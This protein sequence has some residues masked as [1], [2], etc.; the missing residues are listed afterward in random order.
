MTDI[1]LDELLDRIDHAE[2]KEIQTIMDALTDR[3]QTL[4]PQWDLLML[5]VPRNDKKSRIRVLEQSIS[6]LSHDIENDL[7]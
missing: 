1:T 3:F 6:L 5:S 7:P 2:P 4:W